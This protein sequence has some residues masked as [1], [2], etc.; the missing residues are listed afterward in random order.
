MIAWT[1]FT[2]VWWVEYNFELEIQGQGQFCDKSHVFS[3]NQRS[4]EFIYDMI[5]TGKL[6]FPPCRQRNFQKKKNTPTY[7]DSMFLIDSP[8]S[9]WDNRCGWSSQWAK[10]PLISLHEP[11]FDARYL[12]FR[13]CPRVRSSA[14]L[15]FTHR[16][17]GDESS[18]WIRVTLKG[19]YRSRVPDRVVREGKG[20]RCA[21]SCPTVIDEI[22]LVISPRF[23]S[24]AELLYLPLD[25][26]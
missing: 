11:P 21:G 26:H 4:V 20:E 6:F 22:P 16:S 3:S 7:R 13:V 17:P 25:D 2:F 19:R 15:R 8:R 5:I 18:V 14:L 23:L 1:S 9:I 24:R 12:V 10:K